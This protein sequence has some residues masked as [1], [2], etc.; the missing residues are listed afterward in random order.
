MDLSEFL[1]TS[2]FQL[3]PAEIAHRAKLLAAQMDAV[4]QAMVKQS[5]STGDANLRGSGWDLQDAAEAL[6]E[7]IKE[8]T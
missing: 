6:R 1:E 2:A 4:G 3:T 7:A 8:Q 5:Q